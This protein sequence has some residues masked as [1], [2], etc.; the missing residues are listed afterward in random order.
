MLSET[1]DVEKTQPLRQT[2]FSLLVKYISRDLYK[3]PVA[4]RVN[5]VETVLSM[6]KMVERLFQICRRLKWN[7]RVIFLYQRTNKLL[8]LC[9]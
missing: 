1:T 6:E 2:L 8:T 5:P 4:C 7:S 3:R 9:K